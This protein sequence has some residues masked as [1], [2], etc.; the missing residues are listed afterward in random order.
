MPQTEIRYNVECMNC[1]QVFTPTIRSPVWWRAKKREE[2]GYLDALRI[3]GED[4]GCIE[5]PA[6]PEVPF[7][8]FGYDSMCVD[9]NIPCDTFVAAV[10]TYRRLNR[11]GCVVFI[12]GVS[13]AVRQKLELE[14]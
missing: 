4:C 8:V 6:R 11:T 3:T 14:S 10:Q 12:T 2:E 7:R 13:N 1:G 5:Q 9:F